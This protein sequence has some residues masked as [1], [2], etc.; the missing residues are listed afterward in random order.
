MLLD[1][2]THTYQYPSILDLKIGTQLDRPGCSPA[3]KDKHVNLVQKSSTGSLGLR[4]AG[5]QVGLLFMGFENISLLT[6]ITNEKTDQTVW[7]TVMKDMFYLC[8]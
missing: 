4:L 7:F 2:I 1:D 6:T 5:M 8:V 3:K